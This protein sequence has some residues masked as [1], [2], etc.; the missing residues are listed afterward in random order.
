MSSKNI[1]LTV[2]RTV[3]ESILDLAERWL[4]EASSIGAETSTD[5]DMVDEIRE[6]IKEAK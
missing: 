6:A 1:T 4:E 5:T 3:L 2:D